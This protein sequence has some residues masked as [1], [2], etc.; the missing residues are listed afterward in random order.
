MSDA[1]QWLMGIMR[2]SGTSSQRHRSLLCSHLRCSTADHSPDTASCLTG[3]RSMQKHNWSIH[4]LCLGRRGT[5]VLPQPLAPPL[6]KLLLWHLL[7][8]AWG[9]RLPHKFKRTDA[10]IFI[11]AEPLLRPH[12]NLPELDVFWRWVTNNAN[13]KAPSVSIINSRTLSKVQ[14]RHGH[15]RFFF[16]L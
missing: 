12:K 14:V 16:L 2:A 10:I 8:S 9:Q 6:N 5:P 11:A 13:V 7:T 15:L 4:P 1:G 3:A